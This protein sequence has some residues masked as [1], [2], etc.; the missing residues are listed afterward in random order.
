MAERVSQLH[1]ALAD[2][3]DEILR[4]MD[5]LTTTQLE[6]ATANPAWSGKDT[7]A[8]LA[9]IEVR[10]RAQALCA[11][12]GRN[13]TPSE[14][15]DTYNA[16]MVAERGSWPT[17]QIR[18]EFIQE[19]DHTLALVNGLRDDQLDLAMDHP[20]RGHMTVEQ[21]L[22]HITEHMRGHVAEITAVQATR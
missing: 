20:R 7:L 6:G 19:R 17:E 9:S 15:V 10:E 12:E 16:R 18:A 22:G 21:I 1:T 4:L 11:L 14:D 8:H 5:Q 2:V 13:Y 3:H